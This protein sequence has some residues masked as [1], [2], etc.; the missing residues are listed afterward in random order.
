[1]VQPCRSYR[2][3]VG[4]RYPRLPVVLQRLLNPIRVYQFTERILVHDVRVVRAVEDTRCY[5][6]LEKNI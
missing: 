1:M 5:P 4:L 3:K 6:W 2:L